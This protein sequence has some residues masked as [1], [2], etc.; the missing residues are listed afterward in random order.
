MIQSLHI[1]Q[2]V[3]FHNFQLHFDSFDISNK[4]V[5]LHSDGMDRTISSAAGLFTMATTIIVN[6]VNEFKG[7]LPTILA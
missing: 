5:P 3:F 2:S 1:D 7:A 4:T 6:S